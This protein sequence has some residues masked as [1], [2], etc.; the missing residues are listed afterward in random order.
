[1]TYELALKLKESGFPQN[2]NGNGYWYTKD[3]KVIYLGEKVDIL[4]KCYIPTLSELIEAIG[5]DFLKLE[6]FNNA[7]KGGKL[8]WRAYPTIKAGR[9]IKCEKCGSYR[10]T[11]HAT[12]E[13]GEP[14]RFWDSYDGETPEIAVA[15]LYLELNKKSL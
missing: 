4:D 11:D 13:Q 9:V 3:S 10:G 15:N 6:S 2:E 7:K 12:T 1:M 5:E 8:E 14:T